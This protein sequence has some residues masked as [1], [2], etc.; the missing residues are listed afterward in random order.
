MNETSLKTA[1]RWK[2]TWYAATNAYANMCADAL[3][4]GDIEHARRFATKYQKCKRR[5]W[6]AYSNEVVAE[7]GETPSRIDWFGEPAL[8]E[9]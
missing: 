6:I 4:D 7:H 9:P 2:A 5:F 3:S 1:Q 8:D